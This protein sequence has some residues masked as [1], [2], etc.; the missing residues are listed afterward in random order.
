MADHPATQW[1]S[2][3][4]SVRGRADSSDRATVTGSRTAP[5]IS[6]AGLAGRAGGLEGPPKRGNP[7]S[8][9]CP[10][11]NCVI[12]SQ[13]R[14]AMM[15]R[16]PIPLSIRTCGFPA[17]GLP[18]VFLA[19]LRCLRI[20]DGAAQAVQAVPVEPFLCPRLGLPGVQVAAPLFD[21][22]A[23]EPHDHIPVGLAE[24]GGGIAGAEVVAPAA[25]DRVE[26]RDH[27][28]DI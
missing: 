15:A 22:Q 7:S 13:G 4:C 1:K 18:M 19:W 25:Q 21:H 6:R 10:G 16:F 24:L 9:R 11:G 5:V 26:V 2:D 28:A 20:A 14:G 12:G 8:F 23:V 27:V 17:Y 3:V